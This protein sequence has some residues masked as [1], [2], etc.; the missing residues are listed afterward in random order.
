MKIL[1]DT[2]VILDHI[3]SREPNAKSVG[4]IFDMICKD[5]IEAAF[6]GGFQ[7]STGCIAGRP[8]KIDFA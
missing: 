6:T 8:V 3:L 7:Y 5:E 2:N 1:L 4:K